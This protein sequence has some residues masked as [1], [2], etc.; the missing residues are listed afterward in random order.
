MSQSDR[1]NFSASQAAA[2]SE[3]GLVEVAFPPE[4][5]ATPCDS[6]PHATPAHELENIGTTG[7]EGESLTQAL[8]QQIILLQAKLEEREERI[9]LLE[10]DCDDLRNRLKRE[11]HYASQLKA[12]LE[13][14]LDREVP[15]WFEGFEPFVAEVEATKTAAHDN[16]AWEITSDDPVDAP[17]AAVVNIPPAV[18]V[19]ASDSQEPPISFEIAA[20]S[21]PMRASASASMPQ[22]TP[23]EAAAALP[24]DGESTP[25]PPVPDF[26]NLPQPVFASPPT[27][28]PPIDLPSPSLPRLGAPAFLREAIAAEVKSPEPAPTVSGRRQSPASL[29]AVKLPT[30]P[31]LSRR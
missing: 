31:P 1:G 21:V 4:G 26:E 20:A 19:R 24:A 17:A 14:C 8:A 10:I 11:R 29:A 2:T 7:K 25:F 15:P 27:P 18:P 12:A 16:I 5:R 28:R 6:A 9:Q 22:V 13:R 3:D 30:F 23:E